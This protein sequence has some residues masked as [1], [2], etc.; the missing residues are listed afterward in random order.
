[1][2][3]TQKIM[4]VLRNKKFIKV[5]PRC[6]NTRGIP[7]RCNSTPIGHKVVLTEIYYS[8][9]NV[10]EKLFVPKN[11]SFKNTIGNIIVKSKEILETSWKRGNQWFIATDG[12]LKKNIGSIGVVVVDKNSMTEHITSQSNE[13]CGHNHLHSTREELRAQLAA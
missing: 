11:K 12:G 10:R 2:A 1:M 3:G 7:I 9:K 4:I 6:S 5:G 13:E 8:R